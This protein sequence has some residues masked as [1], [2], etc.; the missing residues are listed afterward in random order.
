LDKNGRNVGRRERVVSVAAGSLLAVAGLRRRDPLGLLVAGVGG[1]LLHRGATGHCYAYQALGVNTAEPDADR[2]SGFEVRESLLI[3]KSPEE[4]YAHWRDLENLPRIMSHLKSVE[5]TENGRSRWL[6]TAPAIAG[7]EIAWDAEIVEDVP[8]E[9]ISWRSLPGSKVD[10]QGKV[11]FRRALGDRGTIVRV[12]LEYRP[13][14]G[15]IGKWVAQLFGEAPDQQ[16]HEDLRNFK[17]IM[18]VGELITTQGQPRGSCLG[19]GKLVS[20]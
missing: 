11:E 3:D 19:L 2:A 4:L 14:A 12:E 16:I 9:R 18:E 5:R 17:R 6:A 13:P 20:S 15:V 8:N 10:T 7:G 1:A